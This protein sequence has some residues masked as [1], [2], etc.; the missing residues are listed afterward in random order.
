VRFESG[1]RLERIEESAFYEGGLRSIELPSSV[2]VLGKLSFHRCRLLESVTFES[3]SRLERIAEY[4]FYESGL[5]SIEIPFAV[6]RAE[7]E[8]RLDMGIV[9]KGRSS[10][11]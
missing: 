3:G 10:D 1:S 11:P 9:R 7:R 2:V 5:R 4:A 6:V 8:A